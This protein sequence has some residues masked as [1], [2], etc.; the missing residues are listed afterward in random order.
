MLEGLDDN[1][2]LQFRAIEQ[3]YRTVKAVGDVQL[4]VTRAVDLCS[5]E[6]PDIKDQ[7]KAIA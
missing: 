7:M 4:S 6:N 1:Q 5:K 2:I 3:T